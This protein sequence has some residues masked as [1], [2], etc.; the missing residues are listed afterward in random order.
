MYKYVNST[1]LYG[2]DSLK[3]P[4]VSTR[5]HL[6]VCIWILQRSR[7]IILTQNAT[8]SSKQW[9]P[10]E[11]EWL[12]LYPSLHTSE[13][14]L[15]VLECEERP[16]PWLSHAVMYVGIRWMA[17]VVVNSLPQT[18]ADDSTHTYCISQ[19][20]IRFTKPS[21]AFILQATHAGVRKAHYER[22]ARTLECGF[23]LTMNWDMNPLMYTHSSIEDVEWIHV[24]HA[25]MFFVFYTE[26]C[27]QPSNQS[28][29]RLI[30]SSINSLKHLFDDCCVKQKRMLTT[31]L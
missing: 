26:L 17:W 8:C 7:H 29:S 20:E 19:L 30:F 2:Y 16:G 15:T 28:V 21:T 10:C 24:I 5:T 18:H 11:R 23:T 13:C 6:H 12:T 9:Q 25:S 14:V 27:T 1:H 3:Y 22:A 4:Y 31:Q